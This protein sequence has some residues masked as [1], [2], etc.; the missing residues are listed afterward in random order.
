MAE[1]N[2]TEETLVTGFCRAWNNLDV[3]YIESLLCDDIEYSSQMVLANINGKEAYVNYLNAKFKAVKEGTDPVKAELGY[4]DN[5]PCLILIQ[6]LA[7]PEHAPYS[8]RRLMSDGTI[9]KV[10]VYI[11][12]RVAIIL[13]KFEGN[14]IKSAS[15]CM[16]APNINDVK[17]TGIFPT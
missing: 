11:S 17:R 3:S 5:S 14:K 1:N 2:T 10:H 13:F 16:V 6:Q 8:K 7:T 15:M 12:E 4:F 9:E